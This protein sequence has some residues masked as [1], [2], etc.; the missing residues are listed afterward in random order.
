MNDPHCY[1]VDFSHS[2]M[3]TLLVDKTATSSSQETWASG[4]F[5]FAS[6]G[7]DGITTED[8]FFETKNTSNPWWRCDLER[9]HAVTAFNLVNRQ[10]CCSKLASLIGNL[11]FEFTFNSFQFQFVCTV[12]CGDNILSYI[13]DK[14][15]IKTQIYLLPS[16][17]K[18]F[19][20]ILQVR[21][22]TTY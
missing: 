10:D 17:M 20:V 11:L 3:I 1:I 6:Y 19:P 4:G 13:M 21:E 14:M 5:R 8:L 12:I 7:N 9:T 16:Y 2:I 22:L 15:S 18:F